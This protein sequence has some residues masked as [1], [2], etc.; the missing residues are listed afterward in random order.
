MGMKKLGLN[1]FNNIS[2]EQKQ[3]QDLGQSFLQSQANQLETQIQVFQNALI[4]FAKQHREEISSNAKFRIEFSN[5]CRSFNVDSLRVLKGDEES[6]KGASKNDTF[7]YGLGVRIFQICQETKDINGGLLSVSELTKVLNAD[8]DPVFGKFSR[9]DAMK[10]VEYLKQLGDEIQI[11][12]IGKKE[13]LKT[14]P[15]SLNT[16]EVKVIEVCGLMGFVSI[17]LLRDNFGWKSYRAKSVVDDMVSNGILWIDDQ[18]EH[19]RLF[20]DPAWINR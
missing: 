3:F 11:V 10:S 16:D 6:R 4:S 5:V 7:Y 1:S 14:I 18:D 9:E 19:E 20:W 13:Y 8:A 12:T 2:Q 17:G 15:Q